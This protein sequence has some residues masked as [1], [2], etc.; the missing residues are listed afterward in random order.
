MARNN[1]QIIE[2]AV[3]ALRNGQLV[4]VPTETVYGIAVDALNE[5]AILRLRAVK[6]RG[7]EQPISILIAAIDDM[8]LWARDIPEIAI[9][10]AKQHWPGPLTLVLKKGNVSDSLTGGTDSIGLRMPNHPLT[11]EIIKQLGN[12]IAAPS[13]NKKGKASPTNANEV[14]TALGEDAGLIIDGGQC[15]IGIGSTI[16]DLT[17]EIPRVLRK[18]SV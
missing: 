2:K 13:A 1:R 5:D 7:A 10:L 16:I 4:A 9:K 3:I 14:K 6:E 11:L 18:G 12:G 15:A 17:G 8:A